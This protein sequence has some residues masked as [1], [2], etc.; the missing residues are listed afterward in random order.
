M[1]LKIDHR[2]NILIGNDA[3]FAAVAREQAPAMA[4]EEVAA[5]MADLRRW[6]AAPEIAAALA[7]ASYPPEARLERERA[8]LQRQGDAVVQGKIDRLVTLRAGGRVIGA[9]V[10]DYKSDGVEADAIPALVEQYRPQ[11]E[12]YRAA[13]AAM[14]GLD[15]AAVRARLV[16]LAASV[17]RTVD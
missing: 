2:C 1:I 13:V 7:R 10:L 9:E 11:M 14:Y 17:V 4:A 5:V 6:L 16:L 15:P 12:A 3:T 8:F